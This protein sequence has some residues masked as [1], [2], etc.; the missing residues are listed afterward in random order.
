M[1]L[2]H[3]VVGQG[4]TKVL[5]THDWLSDCSGYDAL[6]PYLDTHH[7]TFAFADLRGYGH[8]RKMGGLCTVEEAAQDLFTLADHLKW[9]HFHYVGH[10]M[11]GMIGQYM[12]V[13]APQRIQSMALITPVAACGSPIPEMMIAFIQDATRSNDFLA[14]QMI[15]FMT[16]TR[17]SQT[18]LSYKV[19]RWRETSETEA[20]LAYL[21]MFSETDFSSKMIGL[22]T[23]ILVILGAKDAEAN[24]LDVMKKTILSW[25]PNAESVVIEDAGHYPTQETPVYLATLI[26]SFLKKHS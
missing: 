17:L 15:N 1:I 16:G 5:I 25:C 3:S 14:Q 18:F 2:G 8:S 26:D 4:A 21:S 12:A 10:S 20:R 9:D 11:S 24:S 13:M 23:P 7:F 22:K 19:N 6:L